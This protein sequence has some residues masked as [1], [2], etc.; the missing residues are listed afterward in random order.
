MKAVGKAASAAGE[1]FLTARAGDDICAIP[2]TSVQQ[3][4]RE[5]TVY[6]LPGTGVELRGLSEYEGEPLVVLDLASVVGATLVPGAEKPVV[7]VVRLVLEDHEELVGLAVAEAID[8]VALDS[9]QLVE[10]SDG[11][12]VGRAAVDGALLRVL[13]LNRWALERWR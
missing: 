6:P 8:I 4:V 13:D 1:R 2:L 12:V 3:V 5:M 10:E 11:A 9:D 7:V